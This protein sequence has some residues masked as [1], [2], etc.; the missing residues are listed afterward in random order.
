MHGHMGLSVMEKVLII[1]DDQM[2]CK[3]MASVIRRM[4]CHVSYC[5][6][7]K[8]GFKIVSSDQFDVVILGNL[9]G[10]IVGSSSKEAMAAG[11][12]INEIIK[13]SAAVLGGG[14]GGRPNLAQGAG[15]KVNN[16]VEALDLAMENLKKGL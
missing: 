5:C 13:E 11:V 6:T 4:E 2:M 9:E 7:L 16:M 14:G 10:K 3:A 15:P 12:K 1:D 8:E